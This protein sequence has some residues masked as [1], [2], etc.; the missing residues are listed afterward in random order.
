MPSPG[1]LQHGI[2]LPGSMAP[3]G[4]R[5]DPQQLADRLDPKP[6]PVLVDERPHIFLRR[7][8][9]ACAKNALARRRISL[10]WRRS[11]FSRARALMRSRSALVTLSRTPVS[12]SY[13]LTH[14]CNVTAA[15]PIFGTIDSIAAHS[16]GGALRASSTSLTARSLVFGE[17]LFVLL[18]VAPFSQVMEP[19]QSPGA[20]RYWQCRYGE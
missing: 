17:Y 10:A 2:T 13:F 8:S 4:G 19:P 14:S 6:L 5:R 7:S 15:H 20:I 9:S 16:E 11:S 18:I 12:F 3:V 1:A